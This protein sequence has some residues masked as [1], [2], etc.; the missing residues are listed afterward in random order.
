MRKA[1]TMH[2]MSDR[3]QKGEG[4]WL[5]IQGHN[6][7]KQSGG[8]EVVEVVP[9]SWLSQ[10]ARKKNIKSLNIN[11]NSLLKSIRK[12]W[13]IRESGACE[14]EGAHFSQRVCSE[15]S[16]KFCTNEEGD[17]ANKWQ[18][19]RNRTFET[20][21]KDRIKAV[22]VRGTERHMGRDSEGYFRMRRVATLAHLA[23]WT[24]QSFKVSLTDHW[25]PAVIQIHNS[26]L[27]WPQQVTAP[28][29]ESLLFKWQDKSSCVSSCRCDTGC[30]SVWK[31]NSLYKNTSAQYSAQDSAGQDTPTS[32]NFNRMDCATDTRSKISIV[33]C[34][35]GFFVLFCFV[36]NAQPLNDL[37]FNLFTHS[38]LQEDLL[39]PKAKQTHR[40][41][42][43]VVE[44]VLCVKLWFVQF[45]NTTFRLFGE[46][47]LI[48]M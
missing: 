35:R 17:S 38:L 31:S 11:I 1:G 3:R 43:G 12:K 47:S 6:Q 40:W 30:T 22:W 15:L 7:N 23:D 34:S 41:Y 48:I 33:V 24:W 19:G 9:F 36:F 45:N 26:D 32:R 5:T 20:E 21:R 28:Q 18:L 10:Q 39:T 27:L 25:V 44:L 14:N 8:R 29:N 4:N 13:L 42:V 2:K 37:L 46:M 16:R